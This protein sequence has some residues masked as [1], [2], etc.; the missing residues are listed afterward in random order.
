MDTMVQ[1]GKPIESGVRVSELL[2]IEDVS[3]L[4]KI[5]TRTLRRFDS[6]GRMPKPIRCGT[7]IVRWR[8]EDIAHWIDWGLCDRKTFERRTKV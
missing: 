8:T 7:R 6:A 2:T 1:L 3:R 4:V 5:A